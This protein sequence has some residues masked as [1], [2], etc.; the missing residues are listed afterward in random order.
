MF[1][2]AGGSF[3]RLKLGLMVTAIATGERSDACGEGLG[4]KPQAVRG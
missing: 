1:W 2:N 4:S 3:F